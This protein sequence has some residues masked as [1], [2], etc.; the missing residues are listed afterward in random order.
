MAYELP[1][2]D[3]PIPAPRPVAVLAPLLRVAN[4]AVQLHLTIRPDPTFI[5]K[6][7]LWCEAHDRLL[8]KVELLQ[9]EINNR[10]TP[11]KPAPA[12]TNKENA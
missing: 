9:G 8:L 7:R 4:A 12:P 11:A 10:W 2:F 3:I 5:E 6:R 1:G